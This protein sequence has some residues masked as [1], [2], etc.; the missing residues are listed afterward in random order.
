MW[1]VWLQRVELNC[2]PSFR[3]V[4][5]FKKRQ[6]IKINHG[7]MDEPTRVFQHLSVS[8]GFTLTACYHIGKTRNCPVNLP[9]DL[10]T[11]QISSLTHSAFHEMRRPF[12]M[13]CLQM[14]QARLRAERAN[15]AGGSR[16]LF[17]TY[18]PCGRVLPCSSSEG[19]SKTQGT[20][21]TAVCCHRFINTK[22]RLSI[23]PSYRRNLRH[24]S[25]EFSAFTKQS[26]PTI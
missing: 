21:A 3:E 7:L 4:N 18:F 5:T 6:T 10:E 20:L 22:P 15:F 25:T 13:T 9:K 19:C 16:Q 12:A 2:A 8:C 24:V 14:Q 11:Q 23:S 17:G 26:V 1:L